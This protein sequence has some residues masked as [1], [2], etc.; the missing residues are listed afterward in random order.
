[1]IVEIIDYQSWMTNLIVVI[2]VLF[3]G[4]FYLLLQYN[5]DEKHSIL[6]LHELTGHDINMCAWY[7]KSF[8]FDFDKTAHYLLHKP[9][10]LS[11]YIFKVALINWVKKSNSIKNQ[12]K[13]AKAYD[14]RKKY[15]FY[16]NP[17]KKR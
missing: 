4:I 8:D 12:K 15:T 5:E 16:D 3:F 17:S 10:V 7:L 6:K 11:V 9:N 13:L 14:P 2:V 1:M